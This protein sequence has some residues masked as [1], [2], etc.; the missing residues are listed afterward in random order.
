MWINRVTSQ[1]LLPLNKYVFLA[2]H[3]CPANFIL[4]YLAQQINKEYDENG[5]LA[6]SGTLNQKML[7][8]LN[9]IAPT[10]L[11]KPIVL[12]YYYDIAPTEQTFDLE[13]SI[14]QLF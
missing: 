11:N 1:N 8:E 2:G 7:N 14:D 6:K 12:S 9:D 13:T 10:E 4:N 3:F 5:E